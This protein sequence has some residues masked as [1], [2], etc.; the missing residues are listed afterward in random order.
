M[1]TADFDYDLP[2]EL[3]A[4]EPLP[5][6][7]RARMLVLNRQTGEIKHRIVSELPDLLQPGDL[8]VVNDTRVIPARLFGRKANSAGRV[9]V[10]LIESLADDRWQA[11]CKASGRTHPGD[12]YHL[13]AG[14]LEATVASVAA[15]G[16]V[17]LQF[18]LPAGETLMTVL[19]TEGVSPLPPY[20]RR[21]RPVEGE[22]LASVQ[23]TAD[24]ERYQTVYARHPGA[25]AAPTAGLHFS[26]RLLSELERRGVRR[27]ALTLHVGPGTFKPVTT[28][29]LDDHVMES[30]RFHI[31]AET[32]ALIE[33]TRHA[34]GR[35]LA[36]GSTTVRALE[37]VAAA[38][39]GCVVPAAGR[40]ALFIRPGFR[41]RVTDMMLTN[42]H[43]PRS[44]LLA[45]IAALAGRERVLAA[46]REA[47]I[48]RYR[49]YSFGDC[50]LI[51]T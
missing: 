13:A 41:F 37:H 45:M 23:T 24:R 42:F 33:Q 26:P 50:M 25:V 31:S 38:H 34:G 30:E 1:Q 51:E 47:V 19:E 11:L 29:C 18:D 43:L 3:I 9:E 40:V 20:I 17:E 35:V 14:R 28:A 48:R 49:F 12:R 2:A 22:R 8:V 15:D 10:L 16:S 6:R 5:E 46:Y 27:A 36:V 4:Q 21:R 44:T 32:A 39:D 7:D